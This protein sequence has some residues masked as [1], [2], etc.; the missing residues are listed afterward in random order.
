MGESVLFSVNNV[1]YY[2]LVSQ[3]NA[4]KTIVPLYGSHVV[5][6]KYVHSVTFGYNK[7][8]VDSTLK[9]AL[10]MKRVHGAKTA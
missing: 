1:E 6:L 8:S 4:E 3:K 10:T 2:I 5:S 7:C 9:G